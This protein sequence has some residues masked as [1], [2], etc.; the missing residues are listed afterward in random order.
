MAFEIKKASREQVKLKLLLSGSS[1]S[2][3]TMSALKLAR[4]MVTDWSKI[5]VVDTE[6]RSAELYSHLGDFLHIDFQPPYSPTRY[7]EV[8]RMLYANKDIE[9]VIVDS[10]SHEWDGQGG[11]LDLVNQYGG[12][13]ADWK[14]VTPSHNKFIEAIKQFNKHLILCGR[15]KTE[16]EI[17]KDD[18]NKTKIE[19]LGTKMTQRDGFEYELTIA[20]KINERHFAEI[21]KDRTDMF[22]GAMPFIIDETTGKKIADWNKTAVKKPEQK[23]VVMRAIE[24]L[25]K[26]SDVELPD[27]SQ[28]IDE[29]CD[30]APTNKELSELHEHVEEEKQKE[31]VTKMLIARKSFIDRVSFYCDGNETK[32]NDMYR[33]I[34]LDKKRLD[35][36]EQDFKAFENKVLDLFVGT[37]KQESLL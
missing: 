13:F 8:L 1:G 21:D 9:C 7:I 10:I 27:T 6:N 33:R 37:S 4:G 14:N 35:Y 17:S 3:K 31:T 23:T 12:R 24:N 36:T 25:F 28:F 34:G 19:K 11:C 29:H 5:C 30:D 20:F 18:K 22:A 15:T 16:Y 32:K 2:G 26:S